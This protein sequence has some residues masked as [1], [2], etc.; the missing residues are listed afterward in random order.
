MP[1]PSASP[2]TIE[3]DALVVGAPDA[4]WGQ[5][6][7][8][9]IEPASAAEPPSL[10]DVR[11][12]CRSRLAGYKAPRSLYL[13]DEVRRSAAGKADYAWARSLVTREG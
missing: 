2:D 12:W 13:V 1:T 3:V 8:A 9:V 10:D 4:R 7:V 6:V 5:R 11:A